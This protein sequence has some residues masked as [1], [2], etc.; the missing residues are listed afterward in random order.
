MLLAIDTQ[1]YLITSGIAAL[2]LIAAWQAFKLRSIYRSGSS[3]F[4]ACVFLLLGARQLYGLIRLHSTIADLRAKGVMIDH[5]TVEQW[6]VG[7]VWIY[8]ILVGF[9]VW[10][11]WK[12]NDL[13][14]LGI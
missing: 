14:K 6:L 3:L 11:H 2:T 13:K 4:G 8:A 12:R 5:L 9:V 10:Q 7:V 1:L